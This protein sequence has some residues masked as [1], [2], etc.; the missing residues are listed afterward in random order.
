LNP[1]LAENLVN[2][3][4]PQPLQIVVSDTFWDTSRP[5]PRPD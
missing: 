3:T 1:N 4:L 5:P 2:Y